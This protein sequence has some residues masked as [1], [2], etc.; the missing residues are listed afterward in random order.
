MV[1]AGLESI[2]VRFYETHTDPAKMA[3]AAATTHR[4]FGWESAT[5]PLDMGVEA[6]ALGAEVDFRADSRTPQFPIVARKLAGSI[7]ELALEVPGDLTQRGRIPVVVEAI[8]LLKE[9]VGRDVVVGA[10]VPG[11]F[12]LATQIVELNEMMASVATEPGAVGRLLDQLTDVLANVALA[13]HAAG[14]DFITIHEMGGSPGVIGPRA[15]Q[16]LV[17][18]RLQRLIAAIPGP[19][20]LSACGRTDR[21]MPLLAE[22]GAEAL[23]VDQANDLAKSR[24]ALGP[25][26]LLFGNLDPIGTLVNGDEA[27]VRQAVRR[28]TDAGADAIWPGCDLWPPVP[29]ANLRTMVEEA[30]STFRLTKA[31]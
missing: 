17:L 23:S 13:Y 29:A 24:A 1:E 4:L 30:R 2:G 11:P 22:C 10:W 19:R 7:S 25:K 9:D 14:S 21:F 16:N 28:A 26:V 15:F 18:P 8:R 27:A 31:W 12:T 5:V 3:A 6:G 20:V